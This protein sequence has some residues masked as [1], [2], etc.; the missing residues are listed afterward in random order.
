MSAVTTRPVTVHLRNAADEVVGEAAVALVI[1]LD[2]D[3]PDTTGGCWAVTHQLGTPAGGTHT[4]V[5][6]VDDTTAELPERTVD[7]LVRQVTLAV[8]GRRWAFH[9]RPEQVADSVLRHGSRLRERIEV[10][11]VEVWA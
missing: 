7:D 3:R 5:T 10:S 2:P 6:F 8:Y 11:A 1:G 9:Y 4:E